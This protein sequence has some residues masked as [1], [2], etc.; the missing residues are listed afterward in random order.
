MIMEGLIEGRKNTYNTDTINFE[1][2]A[3]AMKRKSVGSRV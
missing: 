2:H 3:L 1:R